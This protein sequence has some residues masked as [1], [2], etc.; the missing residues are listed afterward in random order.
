LSERDVNYLL[1]SGLVVLS[2]D[3]GQA[4]LSIGLL[5]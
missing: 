5:L 4:K 2:L 1:N 3:R